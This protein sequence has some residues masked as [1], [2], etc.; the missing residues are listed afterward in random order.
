V[1]KLTF[2]DPTQISFDGKR[3]LVV[4]NSGWE[5]A[6][7]GETTRAEGAPIVAIPLGQDCKPL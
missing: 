7:K 5:R 4:P 6:L 1:E 3:L 2:A